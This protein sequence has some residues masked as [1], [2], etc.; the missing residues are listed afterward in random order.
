MIIS[1]AKN[2]S[3]LF[4]KASFLLVLKG[5]L[6]RS[7][8]TCEY[9]CLNKK[10][11]VSKMSD[12]KNFIRKVA[13]REKYYDRGW[14]EGD[15]FSEQLKNYLFQP[16]LENFKRSEILWNTFSDIPICLSKLNEQFN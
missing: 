6:G 9:F 4:G 13:L 14:G 3:G 1:V 5:G 7:N 16:Q 10:Y 2:Y 15:I 11:A 8:K 12:V